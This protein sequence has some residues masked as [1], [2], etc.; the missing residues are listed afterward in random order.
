VLRISKQPEPVNTVHCPSCIWHEPFCYS[1]RHRPA[2]KNTS[3]GN[4]GCAVGPK[5]PTGAPRSLLKI[6]WCYA[7][8]TTRQTSWVR[9]SSRKKTRPGWRNCPSA[10]REGQSARGPAMSVTSC[11]REMGRG[12]EFWPNKRATPFFLFS[13]FFSLFFSFHF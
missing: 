3:R 2:P 6:K 12:V 13:F 1:R 5:T 8:K 7:C 10:R 9:N 4:P 11:A